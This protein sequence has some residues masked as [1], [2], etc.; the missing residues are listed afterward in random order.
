VCDAVCAN[1]CETKEGEYT[2]AM[3]DAMQMMETENRMSVDAIERKHEVALRV[4]AAE[5]GSAMLS[6][7]QALGVA[8]HTREQEYQRLMHE[9]EQA[10]KANESARAE[11][12]TAAM[13]AKEE[14]IEGMVREHAEIIEAKEVASLEQAAGVEKRLRAEYI[15]V[16]EDSVHQ[17]QKLEVS[18]RDAVRRAAELDGQRQKVVIESEE[19]QQSLSNQIVALERAVEQQERLAAERDEKMSGFTEEADIRLTAAVMQEE[20][21]WKQKV[22]AE[23]ERLNEQEFLWKGRLATAV[24]EAV[25]VE[26]Q[27]WEDKFLEEGKR[28]EEKLSAEMLDER[29]NQVQ[30]VVVEEEEKW[31]ARLEESVREGEEKWEAKLERAVTEEATKWEAKLERVENEGA[32]QRQQEQAVID[33]W[34]AKLEQL[35]VDEWTEKVEQA[36]IATEERCEISLDGAL[37][38]ESEIEKQQWAEKVENEKKEVAEANYAR[39]QKEAAVQLQVLFVAQ[40]QEHRSSL[41]ELQERIE[42]QEQQLDENQQELEEAQ[43]L[44]SQH[45]DVE[46]ELQRVHAAEVKRVQAAHT[47]ELAQTVQMSEEEHAAD[48]VK[49]ME[50][51]YAADPARVERLAGGGAQRTPKRSH[52]KTPRRRRS[53]PGRAW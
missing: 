10:S 49:I 40:Q 46:T 2:A 11:E 52:G 47:Q 16:M 1:Q 53:P 26:G 23:Q 39:G 18:E 7:A 35:I 32:Q 30:Q 48:I 20:E 50:S 42:L 38:K 13:R 37:K 44:H 28:L 12:H 21:K 15:A 19:A 5:H 33:A 31:T 22:V 41:A 25:M 27:K 34:K 24:E 8:L 17:L 6:K 29:E 43:R 4:Q 9:A 3:T 51:L 36:I 14:L 45:Q